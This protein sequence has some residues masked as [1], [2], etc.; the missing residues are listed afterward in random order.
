MLGYLTCHAILLDVRF[1]IRKS[2]L[3]GI[4]STTYVVD[5]TDFVTDEVYDI[6]C[7]TVYCCL[8]VEDFA[9]VVTAYGTGFYQ[10]ILTENTFLST[11]FTPPCGLILVCRF[12][13]FQFRE[14]T[15]DESISDRVI[16]SK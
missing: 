2:G 1:M 12:T 13:I 6:F 11:A 15:M 10:V 3:Q 4:N 5:F 7:F 8:H 9:C 14:F 16:S